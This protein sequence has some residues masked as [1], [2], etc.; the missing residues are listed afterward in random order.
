MFEGRADAYCEYCYF[1]HQETP[2]VYLTVTQRQPIR[3]LQLL[4]SGRRGKHVDTD[5]A[6]TEIWP[7]WII[8]DVHRLSKISGS[9]NPLTEKEAP[10]PGW[11][12]LLLFYVGGGGGGEG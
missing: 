2:F 1:K 11:P 8:L 10:V 9:F 7:D 4:Q 5:L 3:V 6:C 12:L